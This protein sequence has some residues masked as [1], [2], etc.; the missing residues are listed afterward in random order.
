[1]DCGCDSVGRAL[2][3]TSKLRGLNPVFCKVILNKLLS[4]QYSGQNILVLDRIQADVESNCSTN[5]AR[6][7]PPIKICLHTINCSCQT[8]F[9][10]HKTV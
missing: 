2:L 6:T 5:C 4:S 7:M 10:K 1:M 8:T 3:L 9:L